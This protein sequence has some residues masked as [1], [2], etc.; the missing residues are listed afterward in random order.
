MRQLEDRLREELRRADPV[1]TFSKETMLAR[2]SRA[3]RRR[4]AVAGVG[5]LAVC[6]L[7]L[8]ITVPL[9]SGNGPWLGADAPPRVIHEVRLDNV[10][11][12]DQRHGYALQERCT[13]LHPDDLVPP[14]PQETPDVQQQCRNQLLVTSDAGQ[15][16]QERTL[17]ADPAHKDAG[18]E[19]LLGHSLM[20][21]VPTPGSLALGGW[22]RRYWTT[23]DGGTTWQESSTPRDVGPPG[24]FGVFGLDDRP[25][26]LASAPP[27]GPDSVGD[28]N[29]IVAAS[30]GSFWAECITGSCVRVT[31]D[32]GQTWQNLTVDQSGGRV[33]W[34]ATS[35][36]STIYAARD[37]TLIRSV[38]G[39]LT[40]QPLPGVALAGRGADAIALPNGDLIMTR[41]SEAGGMFRLRAG[42]T[43][44]EQLTGAP[45]HTNALYR[46]G[47]WLV[48]A[49]AID[50]RED[51]DL[52]PVAWV[53]PDGGGTW[54]AVPV[55]PQ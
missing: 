45:A 30:D 12:T 43:T 14:A 23:T 15:S 39:G 48:A 35:D 40:W 52:G 5:A 8:T 9:L 42:A 49:P 55:P 25:V 32:L 10:I 34:V 27:G 47:G 24:S 1:V 29:P 22:D 41:A 16:W 3:R 33:D 21:W 38:D 11:F 53:S 7:A 36:G 46:T 51:P 4:S 37:E 6:A 18:V 31:R 50:Q 20:L 26:F 54:I 2:V 44:V 13:M 19:I 28:K 17:P